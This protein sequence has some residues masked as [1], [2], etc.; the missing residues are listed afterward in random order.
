[1]VYATQADKCDQRIKEDIKMNKQLYSFRFD[2][3]TV[4]KLDELRLQEDRNRTNMIERLISQ[5]Y[6]FRLRQR[7]Y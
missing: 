1:M 5:E 3:D 6:E 4:K 7:N 2:N